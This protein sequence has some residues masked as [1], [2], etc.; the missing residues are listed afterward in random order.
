MLSIHDVRVQDLEACYHG[1][2]I[3]GITTS[4]TRQFIPAALANLRHTTHVGFPSRARPS[5]PLGPACRLRDF[6]SRSSAPA[7][8]EHRGHRER[9]L[10]LLRPSEG[11]VPIIIERFYIPLNAAVR[12]GNVWGIFK[13]VNRFWKSPACRKRCQV[14]NASACESAVELH[15]VESDDCCLILMYVGSRAI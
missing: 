7:Y 6:S 8:S 5:K 4:R 2:T 14:G 3:R 12:N 1:R 11:S 9:T 15:R 10:Y 13:P